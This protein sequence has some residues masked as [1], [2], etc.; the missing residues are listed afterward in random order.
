MT[1]EDV[2]QGI[3]EML[4]ESDGEYVTKVYNS[5]S[6]RP[7]KYLGDSI[8]EELP[9]C[10]YCGGGCPNEPDDSEY[11]CDGFAGDIDGLYE[12]PPTTDS[13]PAPATKE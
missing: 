1:Y 6:S 12:P 9:E 2:V 8:W 5:I 3:V 7:I 11:L 10:S 13:S 4:T